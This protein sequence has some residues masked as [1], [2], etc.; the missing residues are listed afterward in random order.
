[1]IRMGISIAICETEAPS[2]KCRELRADIIRVLVPEP[3]R[4][5]DAAERDRVV[6]LEDAGKAFPDMGAFMARNRINPESDAVY[7]DKVKK[8]E[9]A[10]VLEPMAET[11]F[12]GWVVL[13]G[14][15]DGDRKAAIDASR[16]ENRVTGW[17]SLGFDEM[18]AMCAECPLSWDKGRGCMG[19]FGPD[20]SKLPEIAAK[21]GCGLIASVPESAASGRRFTPEDGAVLAQEVEKLTAVL[22]DEGKLMVRRY[23]GPL[24]RLGAVA[25][26]SV[27]EGCGFYFF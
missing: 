21:H 8:A 2:A 17:D 14:L 18:N 19:A 1:M 6:S 4:F 25:D 13:E 20:N 10:A 26:I 22:P 11:V 7:M 24:E 3:E 5:G 27:R 12:T 23:A 15:S 16:P 9:D